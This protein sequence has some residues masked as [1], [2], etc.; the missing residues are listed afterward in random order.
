[1]RGPALLAGPLAP[2]GVPAAKTPKACFG[3]GAGHA[4]VSGRTIARNLVLVTLAV[5]GAIV[6]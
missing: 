5:T 6:Q 1:M 4:P 3:S 2:A